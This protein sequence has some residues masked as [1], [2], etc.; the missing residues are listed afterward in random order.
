MPRIIATLEPESN[1]NLL[2]ITDIA[3]LNLGKHALEKWP[4]KMLDWPWVMYDVGAKLRVI[5]PEEEDIL[6]NERKEFE[7]RLEPDAN[8]ISLNR[9]VD[10]KDL[11]GINQVVI[12]DGLILGEAKRIANN[13]LLIKVIYKKD[14]EV[15]LHRAGIN[16]SGAKFGRFYLADQDKHAIEEAFKRK[17]FM[18]ALSNIESAENIQEAI[19]RFIPCSTIIVPKI[20]TKR[21]VEN[22]EQIVALKEDL[23]IKIAIMLARGDLMNEVGAENFSFF[24]NRVIEVCKKTKTALIIATGLLLSMKFAPWPSRAEMTSLNFFLNCGVSDLCFMLSDETV[25]DAY[26]PER[27]INFLKRVINRKRF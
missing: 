23:K 16:F 21:A 17:I 26:N 3:R 8:Q 1:L 11:D 10:F 24:E 20:E 22:V 9:E 4:S 18:L 25:P 27:T 19:G 6:I 13:A 5:V 12:R 14:V 2:E 7:L 15:P